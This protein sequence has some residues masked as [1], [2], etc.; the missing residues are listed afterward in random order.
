MNDI[1]KK[2]EAL[3]AEFLKKLEALEKEAEMQKKPAEAEPWIPTYGDKYYY[4][5]DD[6]G[7]DYYIC[8]DYISDGY[9]IEV[10]NCFRTKD[11]LLPIVIFNLAFILIKFVRNKFPFVFFC[12]VRFIISRFFFNRYNFF[13]KFTEIVSD[14]TSNLCIRIMCS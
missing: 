13:G 6:F 1:E 14:H 2:M 7:V 4:I 5:D 8:D 10:G 11:I 9:K 12:E 3:K